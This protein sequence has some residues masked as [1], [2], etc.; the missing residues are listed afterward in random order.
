MAGHSKWANIRHRKAAQDAKRGKIF[1]KL[2]RE[3][4]VAAK[5]GGG[6]PENNPRLRAAID[7]ALS[8][9]MTRDTV[10]RAVSRGAGGEGD[11]NMETVIYEGYGPGG[12]AVMVECMTDNRNRT[13]SGVRHA[14]SKAGGNLGTDGSVNYLFDKK[15]VISYAPGLDEDE[16]MEVALEGGADDIETGD[17]GAIDVY[18]T[19]ADFGAVKDALDGAGYQAANAEVTLVPSTK[20]ELDETTAP[21]LLRLI[22]ALEDLDDVQEVYH[23]GDIS[24]EVAASLE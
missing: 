22:D 23:N 24:D 7:K 2:I 4:V 18:T 13:V 3:I 16:V 1:T 10:N 11:D 14:F 5:E 9:N 19:P 20:A 15:G 6:E 17:D 8:N 12:T 21:K